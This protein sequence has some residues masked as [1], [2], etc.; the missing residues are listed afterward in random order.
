[1]LS[2]YVHRGWTERSGLPYSVVWSIEQ[3]PDGYLWLGTRG[4][5]TRYDGARFRHF[6]VA[7]TPQLTSNEIRELFVDSSGVLWIGTYGGGL[8]RYADGTF[9]QVTAPD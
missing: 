4:G 9:A 3:T 6:T 5:L 8:V 1:M 2:Q 7:N